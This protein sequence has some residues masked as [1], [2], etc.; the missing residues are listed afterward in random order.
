[1][2][3]SKFYL[4]GVNVGEFTN[5]KVMGVINCSETSFY[6]GAIRLTPE[7]I[8]ELALKHQDAGADFIDIGAVSTAPVE[9]YQKE[10]SITIQK[11]KNRISMAINAIQDTGVGIPISIDTQRASVA[12]WAIN[13]GAQ[14]IND[15]SGLKTD[16]NMA[17][18]IAEHDASTIVMACKHKPGDVT[19]I[20]AIKKVWKESLKIAVQAGISRQKIAVDPGIG[21]W[22]GRPFFHD[23]NIIQN[24]PLLKRQSQP[25]LIALSRK[26]FLG[27]LLGLPPDQRLF[28]SLSAT[29][30]AVFNGVDIV[31]THDVQATKEAITV[32][33]TLR[34][35]RNI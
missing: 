21:A 13:H 3:S 9:I 32:A 15:I 6:N 28:G 29:A 31:R 1:M 2:N 34:K 11:E 19:R 23:I 27:D 24:L 35:A 30:I 5:V 20:P 22:H 18:V 26:S 7:G 25:I 10:H 16:P 4:A 12:D 33:E 14:I 8:A 17:K